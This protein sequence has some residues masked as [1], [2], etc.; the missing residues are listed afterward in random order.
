[1]IS[2]MK[3]IAAVALFAAIAF[4][5]VSCSKVETPS[6]EG[7]ETP[8]DFNPFA[9]WG[10][11]DF[12]GPI[13]SFNAP[14]PPFEYMLTY[15]YEK[16]EFCSPERGSYEQLEY[17]FKDGNVPQPFTV[18]RL[19]SC[20]SLNCTLHYLGVYFC[21]YLKCDIPEEALSVL[22]T[23]FEREREAG[24]K[25]VLRHAYSWSD[26]VEMMEPELP[27]ILRHIEQLAPIWEEYKD[28]IYVLQAGFVGVYGEWHTTTNI[29]TAEQK[30]TI[31]KAL[32]D[33]FPKD[34]MV[35]VRTVGQKRS[36]M[37]Y[38]LGRPYKLADT[39]T[40]ATAFNGE[41]GSRLTNHCDCYFVNS[42][43]G[44][45]YGGTP[46]K[47]ILRTE[48]NYMT[49][50]GESCFQS[51]Y[52]YCECGYAN[53]HMRDFHLSYLRIWNG[54]IVDYWKPNKIHTDLTSR[55]GNRLEQNGASFYGT[56][57]SAGDFLMKY[58]LT[59]YGFAS[60][61]NERRLEFILRNDNDWTEKYVFV[62]E[63]DPRDWKGCRHY[64]Y[65]EQL[66]L[67]E[68]L[69]KGESYTL[70]INLPDIA[71]ALHDNPD[72]SVRFANKGVWDSLTGYNR[73][74][75]FIAE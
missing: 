29:K 75:S 34:R 73:V 49:I 25:V 17:H 46:D 27:Q 67:P 3:K 31:V 21:D 65:D 28:V 48:G 55:V 62:S 43:D 52:T 41:Y 10:L 72:F 22:R 1:M 30:G 56:Y 5:G 74:A 47:K 58:C 53:K 19:K 69:K 23:H 15:R 8:S 66:L 59:N 35:A 9:G 20:R 57:T 26:K 2:S 24:C 71:P 42:I 4:V 63:K 16:S 70:F 50:G 64:E 7:G 18:A 40:V 61:I 14:K 32:L 68:S 11:A 45:T 60:L 39:T 44:G 33:N 37:N 54:E 13:E 36:A 51:D 6:D 38:L 12:D